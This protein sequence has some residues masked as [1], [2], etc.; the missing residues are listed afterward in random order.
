MPA[1]IITVWL[2]VSA[3]MSKQPPPPRGEALSRME[4]RAATLQAQ[5][6]RLE[7]ELAEAEAAVAEEPQAESD[8]S[9][10]SWGAYPLAGL[11]LLLL[12]LWGCGLVGCPRA[13]RLLVGGEEDPESGELPPLASLPDLQ[14]LACFYEQSVRLPVDEVSRTRE[15]VEGFADDLLEAVRSVCDRELDMELQESVGVGSLY[16]NWRLD[17]PLACDLLVPF[18]P[19]EPYRFQAKL[20]LAAG[21]EFL[22]RGAVRVLGP[23]PGACRCGDTQLARDMLCLVHGEQGPAANQELL[24]AP[25][26]PYLS[27]GPVM[28]WFQAALT[29]AWARISHKYDFEL[30]FQEL[31]RPGSLRIRFRS[32]KVVLFNLCP[33]VQYDGSDMYLTLA[34]DPPGGQA[35]RRPDRDTVWEL[36]SAVYEKRFLNWVAKRLP[37]SPCH[38]ACLQI[39]AFLHQKQIRLS[40]PGGLCRYHLK[41]ALLHLLA[42]LPPA[43][44]HR[45]CLPARL[46]DLLELLQQALRHGRLDHFILGSGSALPELNI[47]AGLRAAQ[48]PNLLAG[49]VARRQLLAQA[50]HMLAEMQRNATVL[51]REYGPPE[52]Q[53]SRASS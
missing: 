44:W 5:K 30:G 50:R 40:G 34:W 27:R 23:E 26:A 14:A 52:P 24:W 25:T 8:D 51:V 32:G 48:Q 43:A 28:R 22:A 13:L 45:S 6:L 36:S 18:S 31:E 9:W 21:P 16:E 37:P 47:P 20:M 15:M 7:Q 19:P 46:R 49:L 29:K 35:G 33:V 2:L 10:G 12:A 17:R 1:P 42:R 11:L 4:E 39:A 3:I 53:T 41:T 38:L